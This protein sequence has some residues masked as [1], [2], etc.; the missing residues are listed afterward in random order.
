VLKHHL[1]SR[2]YSQVPTAFG[3]DIDSLPN[4]MG[5]DYAIDNGDTIEYTL[6]KDR[7]IAVADYNGSVQVI[8]RLYLYARITHIDTC[9]LCNSQCICALHVMYMCVVNLHVYHAVLV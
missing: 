4:P 1:I 2:S 7:I 6:Q 8:C 5:E 9:L 3:L